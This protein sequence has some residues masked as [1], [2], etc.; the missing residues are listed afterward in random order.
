MSFFTN[1]VDEWMSSKYIH[2]TIFSQGL[3]HKIVNSLQI[4]LSTRS[5]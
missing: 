3:K 4:P 2:L 1:D 5:G